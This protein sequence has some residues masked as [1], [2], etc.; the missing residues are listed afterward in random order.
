VERLKRIIPL[1]IAVFALAT[2]VALPA[3]AKTHELRIELV[4][5]LTGPNSIEGTWSSSGFVSDSGSYTETFE[6]VGD[7]IY[8][9]KVLSSS[10]GTITLSV[11]AVA[12]WIDACIVTFSTGSWQIAAGT[13]AYERLKGGGAPAVEPGSFGNVCTGT[14]QETHVGRAHGATSENG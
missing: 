10:S 11:Q 12:E 7:S 1:C 14:V 3:S 4:G 5:H 8:V 9:V 13:G 2:I 6:F